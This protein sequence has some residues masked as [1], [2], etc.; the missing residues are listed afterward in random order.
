MLGLAESRKHDLHVW[1]SKGLVP[2][3]GPHFTNEGSENCSTLLGKANLTITL[4]VCVL[5][6]AANRPGILTPLH[7][8]SPVLRLQDCNTWPGHFSA[9]WSA[10]REL[11]LRKFTEEC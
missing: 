4:C 1:Q 7:P 8:S 6:L 11:R 3:L 5:E 2:L 10:L 9:S